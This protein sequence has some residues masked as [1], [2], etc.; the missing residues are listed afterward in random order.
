VDQLAAKLM[1]GELLA[2]VVKRWG[3]YEFVDHWQQG[4]FHHDTVLRVPSGRGELSGAYLVVATNCNGGVKEVLCF[5][6]LPTRGGLWRTRCPANVEFEGE[7]PSILARGVTD[8][9]FDPCVLLGPGARSE[10]RA[11]CRVRQPGGG[12]MP[13]KDALTAKS[14]ASRSS[15]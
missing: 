7:L 6:T 12:W 8:H 13:K 2:E 11:D 9:W 5:E 15:K 10:Y 1:L 14:L 4:E 3:A